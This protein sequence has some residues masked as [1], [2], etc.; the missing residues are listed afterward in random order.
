MVIFA[1]L[2]NITRIK[3]SLDTSN[4]QINF[5]LRQHTEV[6]VHFLCENVK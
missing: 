6:D 3:L 5:H 1:F 4:S 2:S